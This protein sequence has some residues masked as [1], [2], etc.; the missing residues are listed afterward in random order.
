MTV[1][2][3]SELLQHK[4]PPSTDLKAKYPPPLLHSSTLQ[5]AAAH[6]SRVLSEESSIP[7]RSLQIYPEATSLMF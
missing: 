2:A 5:I 1:Y 4:Q 6:S 7:V 3:V